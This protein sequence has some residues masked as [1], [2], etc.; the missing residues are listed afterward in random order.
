MLQTSLLKELLSLIALT[1]LVEDGLFIWK[2]MS[3]VFWSGGL[4]CLNVNKWYCTPP[5]QKADVQKSSR[6]CKMDSR[7][8]KVLHF[9]EFL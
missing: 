3:S 1:E 5:G 6:A 7:S 9:E 8:L 2:I 4:Q